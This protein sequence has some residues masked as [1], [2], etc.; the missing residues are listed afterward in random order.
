MDYYYK[1]YLLISAPYLLYCMAKASF[2]YSKSLSKF[3]IKYG[4]TNKEKFRNKP[5]VWEQYLIFRKYRRI[6][7]GLFFFNAAI[8]PNLIRL[9]IKLIQS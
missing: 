2:I 7:W 1:L 4:F 3:K 9:I 6:F 8:M 5:E